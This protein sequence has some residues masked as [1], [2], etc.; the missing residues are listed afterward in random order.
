[1]KKQNS[2]TARTTRKLTNVELAEIKGGKGA[3]STEADAEA[4]SA[5]VVACW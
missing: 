3:E 2:K 1:M 4:K 5:Q